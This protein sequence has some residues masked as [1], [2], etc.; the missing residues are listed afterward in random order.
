MQ[1][2]TP[3]ISNRAQGDGSKRK[4]G[5]MT[6]GKVRENTNNRN[7]LFDTFTVFNG[8]KF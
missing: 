2:A 4:D 8:P 5:K 3:T 6:G 1:Q 7:P